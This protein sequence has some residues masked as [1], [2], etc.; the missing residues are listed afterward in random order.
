[1]IDDL[2]KL[3]NHLDKIGLRSEASYLD[4]VLEKI[5]ARKKSKY[6]QSFRV[7]MMRRFT[8]GANPKVDSRDEPKSKMMRTNSIIKSMMNDDPDKLNSLLEQWE[9]EQGAP[10]PNDGIIEIAP[11]ELRELAD[12]IEEQGERAQGDQLGLFS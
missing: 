2:V 3:S 8:G 6:P 11:G 10:D 5:A 9:E 7:W 1:M 12:I 4:S